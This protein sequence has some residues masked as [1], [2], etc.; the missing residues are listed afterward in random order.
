MKNCPCFCIALCSFFA[1]ALVSCADK[2]SEAA[3]NKPPV[4]VEEHYVLVGTYTKKEGHVDGKAKGIS[5]LKMDAT[6]GVLTPHTLKEGIINPSFATF[7]PDGNF[8]YAVS[9]TGG[10]VGASGTV[11][12]FSVNPQT[13]ELTKLNEQISH[14]Y[15]PCH[16]NIDQQARCVFVANYVGGV[17]AVYPIQKDGSLAPAS[18]VITLEGKGAHPEQ[19]ASHPHSV[20]LSPDERFA[21]VP[22]KGSDKIWAFEIDYALG[23]LTPA[24]Q[25]F[26]AVHAGAGPRHLVFHSNGNFAYVINELDATITGFQYDAAKGTLSEIQSIGT[27]PADYQGFNAC[28]D[29]HLSPDGRFLYGS[30]RGHNSIVIYSVNETNGQLTLVGHEPTQGDFPRNFMIA[31]GG[32]WLYVAN[33]NSDNLVHFKIDQT[34][35]KLSYA[36]ET[37]TPTPVCLKSK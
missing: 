37:L 21:F 34:T 19:E 16:I 7:S 9:E 5:I 35:G 10:D 14:N 23:K 2:P 27:L 13:Q 28:A 31:P 3:S 32:N 8:V 25:P 22:D 11:H 24:A 15:A 4:S 30:N 29:I 1:L 6:T 18:D 17:V 36:G 12:A 26:A 20:I 33:Q